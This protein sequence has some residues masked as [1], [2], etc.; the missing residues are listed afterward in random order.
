M[1]I[2]SENSVIACLSPR[3]NNS[4]DPTN[5]GADLG[6]SA[7]D[8]NKLV[9]EVLLAAYGSRSAVS[10]GSSTNPSDGVALSTNLASNLGHSD[11]D[12]GGNLSSVIRSGLLQRVA[13]LDGSGVAAPRDGGDGNSAKGDDEESRDL[14]EHFRCVGWKRQTFFQSQ[15]DKKTSLC[16]YV[17]V[18]M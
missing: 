10:A 15:N 4:G 6:G 1:L 9:G 7:T 2:H 5:L 11:A 18:C 16:V 8:T 13:A 17:C 3:S 12:E 14:G